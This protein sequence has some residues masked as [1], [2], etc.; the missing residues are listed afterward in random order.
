MLIEKQNSGY[1]NL[2]DRSLICD[3]NFSLNSAGLSNTIPTCRT[4][5]YSHFSTS[6]CKGH[7]TYRCVVLPFFSCN[8]M[9]LEVFN[10]SI[11]LLFFTQFALLLISNL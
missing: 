2:V 7:K 9:K 10:T 5:I 4:Y 1:R 8:V 3:V 11:M 6:Y